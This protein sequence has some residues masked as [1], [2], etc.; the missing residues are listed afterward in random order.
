[1]QPEHEGRL[2]PPELETRRDPPLE[3]WRERG[4]ISDCRPP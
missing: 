4:F 3:A 1:M 2:E